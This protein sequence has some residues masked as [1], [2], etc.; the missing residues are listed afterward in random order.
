MTRFKSQLITSIILILLMSSCLRTHKYKFTSKICEKKL[1]V[2]VFEVNSFGVDADYLT[3][4]VNFRKYIG[5]WDEEHEIYSY[6]CEGDSVYILKTVRG[7]RWAKWDTAANGEISLKS[8]LD[9][10]ENLKLSISQLKKL[11]NF[12]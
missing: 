4:S 10:I 2:E 8:N 9:T 1:F 11:D 6:Y 12:K 3:D 7:N 5:D